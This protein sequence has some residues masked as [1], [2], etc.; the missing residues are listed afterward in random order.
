MS[1]NVAG[2]HTTVTQASGGSNIHYTNINYYSHSASASQ[3][4]QD[5]AQDP[6]K[7]TQPV[8]DL[9]K[10]SAVP[11][12]SPS[13]EACGYSDRVAQL[14]LGNST[15]TTQ[16]AANI[17]VAYG[18]WP[19]YLSDRDATAVDKTTK[20]GVSCDRFYT[21]P[22]KKWESESKGWEWKLPDAINDLGVFGQ[23]A[24]YHF[25]SRCGWAVHVHLERK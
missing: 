22:S 21:L 19:S 16:E 9:M 10:E 24:Q 13:A 18:E 3:N 7:F 25:L 17:T 15:I 23:N 11:L 20:P 4:K 5:I 14:T 2:S 1:K 12:K 8:V 6:S